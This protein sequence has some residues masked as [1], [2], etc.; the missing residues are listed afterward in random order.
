MTFQMTQSA[1]YKI[2]EDALKEYLKDTMD[3]VEVKHSDTW[4]Y[5]F[6]TEEYANF[7]VWQLDRI[8]DEDDDEEYGKYNNFEIPETDKQAMA[9]RIGGA[10]P[11]E[12]T[13]DMD[14]YDFVLLFAEYRVLTDYDM[15]GVY[16]EFAEELGY[17]NEDDEDDEENE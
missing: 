6:D 3:H 10:V 2:M 12:K 1:V 11:L 8:T 7:I 9:I 14:D 17:V 13:K 4:V 16:E 5:S 15:Q